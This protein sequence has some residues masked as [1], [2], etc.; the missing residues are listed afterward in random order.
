[1][2]A[3]KEQLFS[4]NRCPNFPCLT[5][6]FSLG[7]NCRVQ[8]SYSPFLL[9]SNTVSSNSYFHG[10]NNSLKVYMYLLRY[11]LLLATMYVL[12]HR[13]ERSIGVLGELRANEVLY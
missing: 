4:S 12:A 2:L 3:I 8:V 13:G 5:R 7:Q 11:D 1:M 10:L 9:T 6:S